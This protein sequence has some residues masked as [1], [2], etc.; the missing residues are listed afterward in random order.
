MN[1][2]EKAVEAR[3]EYQRQYRKRNSEKILARQRK[4]RKENPEKAREYISRYWE[5]KAQ[6]A[7]EKE[8]AQNGKA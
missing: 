8:E 1:L 7:E 2:S 4:W 5:R 3:R 6:E